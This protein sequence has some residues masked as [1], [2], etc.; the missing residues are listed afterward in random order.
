MEIVLEQGHDTCVSSPARVP[1]R[2]C[3]SECIQFLQLRRI[4]GPGSGGSI[5]THE[6]GGVAASQRQK[7]GGSRGGGGGGGKSDLNSP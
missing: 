6:R 1:E 4:K 2:E 5:Q 7:G 3:V